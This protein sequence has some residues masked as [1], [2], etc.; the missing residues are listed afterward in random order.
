MATDRT[1]VEP[2]S[3]RQG[4]EAVCRI[5]VAWWSIS[6]MAAVSRRV[7][8]AVKFELSTVSSVSFARSMACSTPHSFRFSEIDVSPRF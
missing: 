7:T 8:D 5:L 4:E 1:G 3:M 6:R 2:V